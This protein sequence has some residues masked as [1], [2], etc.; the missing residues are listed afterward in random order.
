MNFV[1]TCYGIFCLTFVYVL[2]TQ[3]VNGANL[4]NSYLPA[5]MQALAYYIDRSVSNA[6]ILPPSNL[7]IFSEIRGSSRTNF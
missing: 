7:C 6:V 5:S 1:Q 2:N 3:Q 4:L